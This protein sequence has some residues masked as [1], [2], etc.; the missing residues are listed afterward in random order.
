M[1][2]YG[3]GKIYIIRSHQTDDVYYG[4][5]TKEY[6][7]QRIDKHRSSYKRWKNGKHHYVTAYEI[8]KYDDAYIELVELYPCNSR[9]ELTSREGS[10]IRN[11]DC[12]NKVVPGRTEKEFR[13]DNREYVKE[14]EKKYREDNKDIIN[15]KQN[16]RYKN[17]RLTKVHCDICNSDIRKPGFNKHLLTPLHLKNKNIVS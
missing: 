10:Y 14:R 5:T 12:V 11:N 9:D 6:L 2:N 13:E 15:T 16:L 1:V 8:L 4:S 3:N 7:S 17:A